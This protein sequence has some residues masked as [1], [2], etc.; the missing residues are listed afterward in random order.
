MLYLTLK[1][2]HRCLIY[3]RVSLNCTAFYRHLIKQLKR[4]TSYKTCT[5]PKPTLTN[6]RFSINKYKSRFIH[7]MKFVILVV[8]KNQSAKINNSRKTI[9]GSK[10]GDRMLIQ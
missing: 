7:P 3:N 4:K 10:N 1:M 2:W 9:G 5:K 8:S 6:E